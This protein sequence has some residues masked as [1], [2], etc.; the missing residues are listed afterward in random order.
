MRKRLQRK[1]FVLA[2]IFLFNSSAFAADGVG[3]PECDAFLN[4]YEACMLSLATDEAKSEA[5][6]NLDQYRKV[7]TQ[8]AADPAFRALLPQMC[9]ATLDNMKNNAPAISPECSF[10]Q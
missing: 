10:D 6:K 3:I 7:F 5:Q 2:A 9:R 4:K 8:Q 1:Y